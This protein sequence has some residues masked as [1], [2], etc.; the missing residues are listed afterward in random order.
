MRA[1]GLPPAT[2]LGNSFFATT[3][4]RS[5]R[6]GGLPPATR[7]ATTPGAPR[8]AST[9]NE[10]RGVTPGDAR[11]RSRS[12]S[13]RIS[14]FNEGRGVTPGDAAYLDG[15]VGGDPLRSMR[16]GGLPP[17]TRP[18]GWPGCPGAA[19]AFNE[20]RGVTPGDASS[21]MTGLPIWPPTFNEG[22][23]VTPGDAN[24]PR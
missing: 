15:A 7:G 5:M 14:P 23:G 11:L 9:F 8:A 16:A 13:R 17:A 3:I 24:R 19:P 20:G 22:R 1:G 2:H 10:G 4:Y 12:R 18:G 21:S 6:A